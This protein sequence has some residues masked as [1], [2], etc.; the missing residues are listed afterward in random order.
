[1]AWEEIKNNGYKFWV[2]NIGKT[3]SIIGSGLS[4]TYIYQHLLKIYQMCSKSYFKGCAPR[5][6]GCFR[7]PLLGL[8]PSLRKS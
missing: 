8:A 4:S 2:R 5:P 1:M 3:E 7:D 6:P